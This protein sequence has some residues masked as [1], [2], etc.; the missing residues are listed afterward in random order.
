MEKKSFLSRLATELEPYIPGEQ[1]IDKHFVKL[2]TNENPY[3]PSDWVL[4][5]IRREADKLRLYPDPESM[6]LR[7]VIANY[8]NNRIPLDL[9]NLGSENIFVGN[10][11]D[12]VLGFAF[13]AFFTGKE[14]VSADITYSFYPVYAKL[15]QCDYR[16]IP[17]SEDFAMPVDAFIGI[18]KEKEPPAGIL[19]TN[20]NAPTGRGL[21]R[22]AIEKIV[23]ANPETLV[24]VD[25]AYIDFGG[26]SAV[27]LV[28]KYDNVLVVQTLSKSRSLAGLRVGFAI[29]HPALIDGLN[30]VKNSF[31]SY[32]VDRLAMAGAVAA[33]CDD[34]HFQKRKHQIMDTRERVTEALQEM[35]FHVVE[36]E[37]NF[38]FVSHKT[39]KAKELFEKLREKK[40]LVRYFDKPRIDNYLRITIGTDG[41]MDI[42]LHCFEELLS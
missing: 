24:L 17:L 6:E 5:S 13:P 7:D 28:G 40:V 11:S 9:P 22:E 18:G 34:Y 27:E 38:I 42:L 32:T 23:A 31:N 3:P 29:G 33:I 10:G 37:A 4:A 41:E 14:V 36:S 35:D 26:E 19:I 20:P 21:G 16:E 8:W 1:P 12:E 2:N 39:R 15:F 25:E 30:R